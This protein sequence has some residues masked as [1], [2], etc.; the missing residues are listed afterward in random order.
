MKDP[1]RVGYGEFVRRFIELML[2]YNKHIKIEKVDKQLCY[3]FYSKRQ[4]DFRFGVYCA[5]GN[6]FVY[7]IVAWPLKVEYFLTKSVRILPEAL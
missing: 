5:L 6:D 3:R 2:D 4:N 1:T 7:K